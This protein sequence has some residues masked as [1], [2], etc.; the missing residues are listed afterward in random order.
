MPRMV[1]YDDPRYSGVP[2]LSTAMDL[3]PMGRPETSVEM[4]GGAEIAHGLLIRVPFG[5]NTGRR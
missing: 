3:R 4:D 2:W 5:V 1:I